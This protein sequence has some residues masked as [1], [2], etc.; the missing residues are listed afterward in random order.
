MSPVLQTRK[1]SV[2]AVLTA[3]IVT[4]IWVGTT[5]P[6]ATAQLVVFDTGFEY[7][8]G[9]PA[10]GSDAANLNGAD[11]QIGTF[12]GAL[13]FGN[14]AFNPDLMGFDDHGGPNQTSRILYVDRP[15]A[16]G[17]FFAELAS[18]IPVDGATV[19]FEVGTRRSAGDLIVAHEKDYDIIG[20]DGGGNESFHLRVSAHSG[21]LAGEVQRI[22]V[23]SDAGG[24]LNWDLQ[25]VVGDDA[26]LDLDSTGGSFNRGHVGVLNLTLG[27]SGYVLDFENFSTRNTPNAYTT[28]VLPYNGAASELARIEFTFAGDFDANDPGS[29]SRQGGYVLDNIHVALVPEPHS[30]ALALIAA[31]GMFV[32]VRTESSH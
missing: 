4:A 24:T 22:G 26:D 20:W 18:T 15:L 7:S 16:D 2:L 5:V 29:T 17:S 30:L 8:G 9:E 3:I 14:G 27:A 10:I 13:P 32:R 12:S 6:S 25:T 31:A 21:D 1:P 19:S 11:G 28:D 23:I